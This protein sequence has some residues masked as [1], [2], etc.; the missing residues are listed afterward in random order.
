MT[1]KNT[2]IKRSVGRPVKFENPQELQELIQKYL[3]NTNEE[4]L[5]LTWL[6]IACWTNKETL[7]D[8]EKKEEFRA[9]IREAKMHIENSYEISLRENGRTWD[10]FALKNFWWKDKSEVENSWEMTVKKIIVWLPNDE[11]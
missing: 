5:T 4:R 1:I 6:C 7:S 8:Y 11:E 9:I 10:I 3:D 2:E